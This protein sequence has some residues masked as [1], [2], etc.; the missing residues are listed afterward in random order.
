MCLDVCASFLVPG[1][2]AGELQRTGMRIHGEI[3]KLQLAFCIDGHP[4]QKDRKKT[5]LDEGV[6]CFGSFV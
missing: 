5:G 1:L 4:G 2:T 3:M 6:H